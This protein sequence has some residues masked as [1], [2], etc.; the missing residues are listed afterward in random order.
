MVCGFVWIRS[1]SQ[2]LRGSWCWKPRYMFFAERQCQKIP[3]VTRDNIGSMWG[4]KPLGRCGDPL[5]PGWLNQHGNKHLVGGLEHQFYFP[6]TIGNFIIPIDFHIFQGGGP[7]TNQTCSWCS[8][9][10]RGALQMT[11][12]RIGPPHHIADWGKMFARNAEKSLGV[13]LCNLEK[14]GD[15][16]PETIWYMQS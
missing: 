6:M 1:F 16:N 7:T 8:L 14:H 13:A 3:G 2:G 9:F 11:T 5:L 12:V 4:T 10:F 15:W